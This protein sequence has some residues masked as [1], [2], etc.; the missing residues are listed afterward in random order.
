MN[1][2]VA[3]CGLTMLLFIVIGI[4]FVLLRGKAAM[5]ISG[6]NTLSVKER[7][8]HD[9]NAMARD[10]RN[11]CFLRA[12]IMALGCLASYLLTLPRRFWRLPRRKATS[13]PTR[14]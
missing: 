9:V 11:S 2:G 12:A 5:L 1:I 8:Q 3:A 14:T 7:A 10:M 6:F 13:F 4:I